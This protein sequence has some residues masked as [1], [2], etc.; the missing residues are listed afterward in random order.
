[1][2]GYTREHFFKEGFR[3]GLST[4]GKERTSRFIKDARGK[5]PAGTHQPGGP[6]RSNTELPHNPAIPLLGMYPK[7][8]KAGTQRKT[9]IQMFV[10]ALF[11]MVK[12]AETTQMTISG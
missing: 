7:E 4:T 6:Y 3:D 12:K 1:M 2:Q 11:T 8:L 5:H 9:C 10:A